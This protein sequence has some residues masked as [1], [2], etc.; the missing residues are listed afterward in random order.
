MTTAAALPSV[1]AD[2][3]HKTVVKE[4]PHNDLDDCT[5]IFTF[6]APPRHSDAEAVELSERQNK[7]PKTCHDMLQSESAEARL[8][9]ARELISL[10]PDLGLPYAVLARESAASEDEVE[11]L[12]RKSIEFLLIERDMRDRAEETLEVMDIELLQ[13]ADTS[14]SE[15]SADYHLEWYDRAPYFLD[16]DGFAL[17]AYEF[18]RHLWRIGKKEA[19][20]DFVL[21]LINN[22]GIAAS[23]LQILAV[24]YLIQSDR[25]AEA[26]SLL[27]QN[28]LPFPEWF[29][30][31]ALLLFRTHGDHL[32]SRSALRLALI[33]HP[34]MGKAIAGVPEAKHGAFNQ[35]ESLIDGPDQYYDLDEDESTLIEDTSCAWHK[36]PGSTEWLLKYLVGQVPKELVLKILNASDTDK[37]KAKRWKVNFDIAEAQM[38]RENWKEAKK[39]A[40][41]AFREI[42]NSGYQSRALYDSVRQL[43]ELAEV[44]DGLTSEIVDFLE[45]HLH[46]RQDFKSV[47]EIAGLTEK[48]ASFFMDLKMFDRAEKLLTE[49]T[50]LMEKSAEEGDTNFSLYDLATAWHN[51]AFCLGELRRYKEAA[52]L[53]ARSTDAQE[54]YL[55]R[56]HME[57]FLGLDYLARCLH[58]S[59]EHVAEAGVRQ[60]LAQLAESTGSCEQ[61]DS[62]KNHGPRCAWFV[63]PCP[64]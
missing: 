48:V 63:T 59:G 31:K 37:A 10:R 43:I 29:Y 35:V 3:K 24:S 40:R 17:I 46:Q 7:I 62:H 8:A 33:E 34:P 16:D 25:D 44:F 49:S 19:A 55:G 58:H 50:A 36:T 20:I 1:L 52:D 18:T 27:D 39:Y 38:L 61:D 57:N 9:A 30:S 45:Q 54:K 11:S 23:D 60:R 51:L 32:I 2:S 53:F 64:I 21:P 15:A 5:A 56:N 14:T 6:E 22:L 12:Y 13:G 4:G 47:D 28:P 41:M 26:Q 42:R